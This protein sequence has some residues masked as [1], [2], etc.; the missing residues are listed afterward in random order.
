MQKI[1]TNKNIPINLRQIISKEDIG[2]VL[3]DKT[4][5]PTN[6]VNESEIEKLRRLS[7]ELKKTLS[8]RM[9]LWKR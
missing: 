4:G 6:I 8:V 3:A 1:R 7:E 9:K 2:N 5:I